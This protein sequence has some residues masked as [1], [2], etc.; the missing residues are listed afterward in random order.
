MPAITE[1]Y[2]TTGDGVRL[3]YQ[4]AGN[5]PGAVIIPN[6]I[7][8][9]DDFLRLA[10]SYT[11]IFFDTRN[12]GRSETL[13]DPALVVNGIHNDVDD[14]E[15]IRA[16]FG[17]DK[18][19]VLGH[20]YL[21]AMVVLYA[22]KYPAQVSRAVQISPP[23]PFFSRQYETAPPDPV[24]AGRL[25]ALQ[26]ERASTDPI[27][28]CRKFWSIARLMFVANPE[29]A[30]KLTNWGYCDVDNERNLMAYLVGSIFP[31][32]HV[33][34]LTAED[35]GRVQMPVLTIHGTVDCS[36]PYAGGKEWASLLP[37]ARLMTVDETG[38]VPWVE[39]SEVFPA[40]ETFLNGAWPDSALRVAQ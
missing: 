16:H 37:N 1:G 30:A 34:N 9:L 23:P 24:V 10:A 20:S 35:F 12:R 15:T 38:H 21:A 11:V 29:N 40:I 5:G 32:F 31:S 28:F 39:A 8:M 7:Y 18:V 6:A 25:A 2:I 36:A 26:S 17:F 19:A 4:Q 33:L 3:F 27:E 13:T 22:M 14:L